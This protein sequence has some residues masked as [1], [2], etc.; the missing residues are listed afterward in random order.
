MDMSAASD[1]PPKLNC[2]Y[3]LDENFLVEFD[4]MLIEGSTYGTC[5]EE[6]K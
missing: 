5:K 3:K 4:E 1:D 2:L 6:I